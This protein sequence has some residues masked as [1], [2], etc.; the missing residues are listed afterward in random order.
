[1]K[2]IEIYLSDLYLKYK[3]Y[4]ESLKK[5]FGTNNHPLWFGNHPL[6]LFAKDYVD[7]GKSVL[8]DLDNHPFI[9]YEYERYRDAVSVKNDTHKHVASQRIIDI[10]DSIKKYGYCVGKYN[11]PRHMINVIKGFDS[12]YGADDKGFTLHTRKHRSAA[13]IALGIKKIRVKIHKGT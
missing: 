5:Y 3:L 7:K 1:M 13:C 11:Q 12:P 4:Y 6:S 10:V 8:N 9:L 2:I